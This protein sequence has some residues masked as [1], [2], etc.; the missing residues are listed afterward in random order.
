LRA[1]LPALH[2]VITDGVGLAVSPDVLHP[3][4]EIRGER[5]VPD[6]PRAL[7]PS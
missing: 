7:G 1:E 2:R 6:K 5:Y 4:L 3:L